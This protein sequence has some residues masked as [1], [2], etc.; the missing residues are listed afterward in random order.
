MIL[1][2]NLCQIISD[3]VEILD[4]FQLPQ[5]QTHPLKTNQLR[6]AKQHCPTPPQRSSFVFLR[7]RVGRCSKPA[8]RPAA[9]QQ[10]RRTSCSSCC[11]SCTF[12]QVLPTPNNA[13]WALEQQPSTR[14]NRDF[15]GSGD[16]VRRSSSSTTT[17][18]SYD[19]H[20]M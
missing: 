18:T 7:Y 2:L 20:F 3:F 13:V 15:G 9:E 4:H 16:E 19:P 8:A 12:R 17:T 14:L 1:L 10:H 6:R 11:R 5:F